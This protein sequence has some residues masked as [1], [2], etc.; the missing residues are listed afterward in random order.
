MG[1]M[2]SEQIEI[3]YDIKWH[4]ARLLGAGHLFHFVEPAEVDF[5]DANEA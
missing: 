3:E 2:D 4:K 5:P 1:E